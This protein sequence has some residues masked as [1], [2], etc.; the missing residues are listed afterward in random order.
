MLAAGE[1]VSRVAPAVGYSTPS[2]F[3]AMFLRHMGTTPGRY[4]GGR[5][6]AGLASNAN[7]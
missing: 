3:G 4:F 1:P 2:A 5:N 7:A 6:A